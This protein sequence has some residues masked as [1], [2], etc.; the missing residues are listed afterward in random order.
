[1]QEAIQKNNNAKLKETEKALNNVMKAII[2]GAAGNTVNRQLN[3]LEAQKKSLQD[4]I[5]A[6]EFKR[7][8]IHDEVSIQKFFGIYKAADFDDPEIRDT[9]LE[10]FVEI[11]YLYDYHMKIT[12]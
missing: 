5:D 11:I 6:E 12:A 3:E 4:A 2:A 1:M 7:S 10:Y 8:L 9:I